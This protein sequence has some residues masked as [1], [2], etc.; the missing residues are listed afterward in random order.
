MAY[1]FNHERYTGLEVAVIG[2]AARFPGANNCDGLWDVLVNNRE[3]ISFFS[4]SEIEDFMF[5]SEASRGAEYVKARGILDELD[6]FDAEL[7]GY[8]PMEARL[9]D[10]QVRIF[11]EC[12]WEAFEDSGYSPF[13]YPGLIG[14]FAGA[15]NNSFWEMHGMLIHR[16]TDYSNKDFLSARLSYRLNL[17]GPSQTVYTACSTSLVAV[18]SACRSLL[19]GECSMAIAGGVS[20]KM[21]QKRGYHYSHEGILSSSGHNKSFDAAADGTVFSNGVGIVVLKLLEEAM[22]DGDN[23]HA[24]IKGSAINNDG[25]R[26]VSFTAPSVKGQ[27]GV[28]RDALSF[29]SVDP[30]SI[31]YVEAHGSATNL[32]DPIEFEA[33][34]DAFRS[35]KKQFCGLGSIKSNIGHTNAAAGVAGLLKVI[36]SLKNKLIPASLHYNNA[37]TNIDFAESPFFVVSKNLDMKDVNSPLTMGVTSLGVGGTNVHMLLEE[38]PLWQP[39]VGHE[40]EFK[41]VT[42]SAK[43]ENALLNLTHRYDEFF[44]QQKLNLG[45][46]A[47]T[48]NTGRT[49]FAHRAMIVCKELGNMHAQKLFATAAKASVD[50]GDSK[51]TIYIFPSETCCFQESEREIYKHEKTFANIL[52]ECLET[53]KTAT[54]IRLSITDAME[55]PVYSKDEYK[56]LLSFS[57][58]YALGCYLMALG[59][60]PDALIG[61]G[62]GRVVAACISGVVTFENAV[63]ALFSAVEPPHVGEMTI[64]IISNFSGKIIS[65]PA[66]VLHCLTPNPN[67]SDLSSKTVNELLGAGNNVVIAFG[68]LDHLSS[69]ARTELEQLNTC[70]HLLPDV[71]SDTNGGE[72]FTRQIGNIWL[73]G[74]HLDWA[75]YYQHEQ[76]RR[77]SLPTYAFDKKKYA[78]D[79]IDL[80]SVL[81]FA[82]NRVGKSGRPEEWLYYPSWK[83]ET[84]SMKRTILPE[85]YW[86][87]FVNDRA[88]IA[89]FSVQLKSA[90]HKANFVLPAEIYSEEG[91]TYHLHPSTVDDYH[92]LL[93]RLKEK[94]ELPDKIIHLFSLGT[95]TCNHDIEHFSRSQDYG[96]YSIVCLSQA[97]AKLDKRVSIAVG[98]SGLHTVIGTEDIERENATVLGPMLIVPHEHLQ[99]AFK[100]VDLDDSAVNDP[101]FLFECLRA[102]LD[103]VHDHAVVA[104]RNRRRWVQG[105]EQYKV[106]ANMD[107]SLPL[108][109]SGGVYIVIGGLGNIGIH[110][111]NYVAKK[112]KATFILIG[113]KGFVDREI[114]DQESTSAD[115]ETVKKISLMREIEAA[116]SSVII[117]KADVS[118]FKLMEGVWKEV[119]S[120]FGKIDGVI[121]SAGLLSAGSNLCAVEV[122]DNSLSEEQFSAKVDGLY[123]LEKLFQKYPSPDFCILMSSLA[124]ILGGLGFTIYCAANA[125]MDVF[126]R[127]KMGKGKTRWMTMNWDAWEF[128]YAKYTLEAHAYQT[129]FA[130]SSDEALEAFNLSLKCLDNGQVIIST[131]DIQARMARHRKLKQETDDST[132]VMQTTRNNNPE[133]IL[134]ELWKKHLG[135]KQIKVNDNFFKLGGNSFL[136]IS[137][138]NDIKKI[139]G[140][141]ISIKEFYQEPKISS[142]VRLIDRK[143]D[144]KSLVKLAEKKEYYELSAA[145]KGIY[146]HYALEP[147]RTNY[148]EIKIYELDDEIDETRLE[149]AFIALIKRHESLRTSFSLVRG[150]PAQFVHSHVSFK[151]DIF[152]GMP[153]DVPAFVKKLIRPFD[154]SKP[155]LFR[156]GIVTTDSGKRYMVSDFHHII[157]DGVSMKII[158]N[159]IIAC[160]YNLNLS[161]LKY[162]YRDFSELSNSKSYRKSLGLQQKYWLKTLQEF[163]GPI[164]LPLDFAV[165]DL[166]ITES[167]DTRELIIEEKDYMSIRTFIAASEASLFS[168]LLGVLSMLVAKYSLVND[169]TFGVAVSGRTEGDLDGIVGMFVNILPFRSFP[170]REKVFSQFLTEVNKA[171]FDLLN[172]QLYPYNLLVSDIRK[173]LQ[174]DKPL[175][176][177]VFN[178][179]SQTMMEDKYDKVASYPSL[180]KREIPYSENRVSKYQFIF[181]VA[182][183]PDQLHISINYS[184]NQYK[185]STVDRFLSEY[186]HL[187]SIVVA[188]KDLPLKDMLTQVDR[189]VT[190]TEKD[191]SLVG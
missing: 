136:L 117:E 21:P 19:H 84:S 36:L 11:H 133:A 47:Y 151:L 14:V 54:G 161:P 167:E 17:R 160:Y 191:I 92:K 57:V 105:F 87:V 152:H 13:Y 67:K 58:Q 9:L 178:M 169:V 174:I 18:H 16:D 119:L 113:R 124:T 88:R 101:S 139:F 23:I 59:V 74:K 80:E 62:R 137:L 107:E 183:E 43:T 34:R 129:A 179:I 2:M 53:V 78:L 89:E 128:E 140:K 155:P 156:I 71:G 24:V 69:D 25:D 29:A 189:R 81:K 172:N 176:Q 90:G 27:V 145:Q 41:L 134:I 125:F 130:M 35:D 12:A 63:A 95:L 73:A 49:N 20:A 109:R 110:I 38:T 98:T 48:I 118:N 120:Q 64:P 44:A 168:F 94:G 1:I 135:H 60:R 166:S 61:F 37:N 76:H 50:D 184:R 182:E 42:F 144:S 40:R 157:L 112:V 102:E 185:H 55:D 10:P 116:G 45:D 75:A 154:L 164:S 39:E 132:V 52:E 147:H 173:E 114:W 15:N 104:Y 65:D 30:E 8:T 32:G 28:I 165:P 190:L 141:K 131:G 180:L 5:P 175:F 3:T 6:D 86:L 188:C 85:E 142:L 153:D 123:V 72:H 22:K 46:A 150:A 51:K 97:L 187:L 111:A 170:E 93:N 96:Y 56:L 83:L 126:V 99:I 148:N 79:T 33:L 146:F 163:R 68:A 181:N 149:E 26:K 159:D 77:I 186:A 115:A 31:S 7:F 82:S 138:L 162:Q 127:S 108:F 91:S 143:K 158:K 66:E 121:H 100:N 177:I 103:N 70:I 122:I 4:D 106:N 171:N